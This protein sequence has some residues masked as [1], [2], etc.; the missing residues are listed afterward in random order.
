MNITLQRLQPQVTN[1]R[2]ASSAEMRRNAKQIQCAL[3]M[4]AK[5]KIVLLVERALQNKQIC[6]RR[7]QT[8]R[9]TA[10][11]TTNLGQEHGDIDY[12]GW[13]RQCM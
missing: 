13:A 8:K 5:I 3:V 11:N 7:E 10:S 12:E 4:I 9:D 6:L 1:E 2:P